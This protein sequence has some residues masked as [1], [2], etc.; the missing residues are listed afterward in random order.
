MFPQPD[1]K[2]NAE[3]IVRNLITIKGLHN[4]N[5]F[6]LISA[7]EFI[8]R[9]YTVFDFEKLVAGAFNLQSVNEAFEYAVGQNPYRVGI[10]IA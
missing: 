5:D 7:V 6:D 10:V 9:N 2:I 3:F 4:Y 1:L 8:E